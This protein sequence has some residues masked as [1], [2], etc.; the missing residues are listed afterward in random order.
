V[1]DEL[2]EIKKLLTE[3]IYK[4]FLEKYHGN[5]SQFAKDVQCDEKTIRLIFDFNQGITMN[6]FF[7]ISKALDV[8]PSELLKDLKL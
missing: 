2:D 4:I 5:K 8:E 3:R 7:K 1:Q 6:L